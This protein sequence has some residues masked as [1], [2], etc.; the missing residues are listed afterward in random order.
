MSTTDDIVY[1]LLQWGY[2]DMARVGFTG[3][4]LRFADIPSAGL[5]PIGSTL[6]GAG[7]GVSA[8]SEHPLEAAEFA[9]WAT[10]TRA[11][12]EVVFANGGQPGSRAA[13][14]DAGLDAAA[15]GFFS[16]TLATLEAA[17][18][19]PRDPWFPTVQEQGGAAIAAGLRDGAD[20]EAIL[21]ELERIYR[22]ARHDELP[23]THPTRG[24][25]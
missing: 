24:S 10:G 19:R 16:A 6:G 14:H 2:T 9:A 17:V 11:Q 8:A 20:P 21:D 18:L 25:A 1:G 12:A 13:W 3:R 22:A 15:G 5:G 23:D 7:L 4:R